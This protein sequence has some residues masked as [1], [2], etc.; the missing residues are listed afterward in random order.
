M[1]RNA[2]KPEVSM[3]RIGFALL[4]LFVGYPVFAFAGYWAIALF[5]GNTF[6]R[7]VEASMTSIFVIG[8][9]GAVVGLVAALMLAA[10]LS[11]KPAPQ[12]DRSGRTHGG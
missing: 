12:S 5:S 11:R 4:G 6:D 2:L 1:R 7:S 9:I 10:A 8:P 3:R